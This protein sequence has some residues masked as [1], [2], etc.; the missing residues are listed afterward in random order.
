MLLKLDAASRI[1]LR[2][3]ALNEMAKV[4]WTA[5]AESIGLIGRAAEI[6]KR[7]IELRGRIE[8]LKGWERKQPS[9][10]DRIA[11]LRA[12]VKALETLGALLETASGPMRRMLSTETL[13]EFGR[14]LSASGIERL[15]G[16]VPWAISERSV[17]DLRDPMRGPLRHGSAIDPKDFDAITDGMRA[18]VAVQ[19]G[20]VLVTKMLEIVR[21]DLVRQLELERASPPTGRPENRYRNGALFEMA[22]WFEDLT[23][24]KPTS[25]PGGSF[26]H[27]CEI[28]LEQL[29]I[30]TEGL[31]SALPRVLAKRR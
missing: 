21:R 17:D 13:P 16:P 31:E 26:A 25:S 15:L 27:F 30:G 28:L 24:Q 29:G 9:R 11:E 7:V 22:Q 1:D 10:Q 20:P 23:G 5:I 18:A 12:L 8:I 19:A 3:V 14:L 2:S 6:E 4:D